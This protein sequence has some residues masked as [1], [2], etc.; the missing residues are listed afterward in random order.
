MKQK[1]TEQA[2]RKKTNSWIIVSYVLQY[3]VFIDR[4]IN[5]WM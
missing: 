1:A 3:E 5:K 2:V 4:N